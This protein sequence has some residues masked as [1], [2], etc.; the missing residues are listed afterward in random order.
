MTPG[1]RTTEHTPSEAVNTPKPHSGKTGAEQEDVSLLGNTIVRA[2]SLTNGGKHE[3]R[4]KPKWQK[5][6]R[7]RG[8]DARNPSRSNGDAGKQAGPLFGG[9][10]KGSTPPGNKKKDPIRICDQ[11]D[12]IA[13]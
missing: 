1:A 3:A 6:N 10:T 2:V 9:G 5:T 11:M 8:P 4:K 12:K 13:I 7:N